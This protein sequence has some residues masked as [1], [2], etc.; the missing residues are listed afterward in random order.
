M[1]MWTVKNRSNIAIMPHAESERVAE[2]SKP[3]PQIISATPLNK[4][5]NL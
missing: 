3:M 1:K 2:K 4:T 5:I